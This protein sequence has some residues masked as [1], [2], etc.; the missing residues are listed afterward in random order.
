MLAALAG[1]PVDRVPVFPVTTR[2][3]GGRALGRQVGDFELE[4]RLVFQGMRA[5]WRRFGVDGLEC[6]F[7]P[8]RDSVPPRLEMR[9]GTPYLVDAEGTPVAIFQEDDDPLPLHA[10]PLLQE[11]G[12]LD[13]LA[14]TPAEDY[15]RSG[16]LDDLRAL[17][18]AVGD[19]LAIAGCPASQ[20]MNSLA[21][22]RGNEQAIF[23]LVDDPEFAHAA[24][25]VATAI[26]IEAGKAYV[27]AGVDC[28]YIGDAWSSASVISPR[29]FEAF[30]LPRYARAVEEFHRLGVPVYLHICGNCMPL[31]EMMADT[32]VDA[33]EPLDALGGVVVSEVVRRVG[34]RV[35]LK[36][37]VST[38]TLLRGTPD[39]VRAEARMVLEATVGRC[40]GILLGS[41]D[42]IP[43]DT[44]FANLD[45]MVEVARSFPVEVL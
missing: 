14:V 2:N 44:P 29:Q 4:P 12:D 19:E 25:D 33:I 38:L 5:I 39:E 18:A 16:R 3:L 17:R 11:K 1:E 40:R 24:M 22:W 8:A 13:Q 6:G 20:T 27:A 7:G 21:A 41:G 15:E 26:S 35:S 32:G 28:L 23:D 10:T 9:D 34:H 36:G 43:R 30:C 37:G 45:A 42:D 31:L